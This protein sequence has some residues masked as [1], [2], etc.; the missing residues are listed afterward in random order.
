M[1]KLPFDLVQ[2][3]RYFISNGKKA[4]ALGLR[5]FLKIGGHIF[6]LLAC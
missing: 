1:L 3:C 5:W 2:S 6:F 4:F